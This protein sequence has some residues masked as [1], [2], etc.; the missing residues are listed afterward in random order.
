MNEEKSKNI[1]KL[2]EGMKSR[3]FF[4]LT[5]GNEKES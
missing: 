5:E 1:T 2:K 3:K 4:F